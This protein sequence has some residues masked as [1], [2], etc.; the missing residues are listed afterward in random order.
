[1]VK[2]VGVYIT[3]INVYILLYVSLTVGIS[4]HTCM[5]THIYFYV[6]VYVYMYIYIYIRTWRS[7]ALTVCNFE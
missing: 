3:R 7:V 1:M 2:V 6:Y 5:C 4:K